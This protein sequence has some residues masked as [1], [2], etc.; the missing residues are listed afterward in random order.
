MN[1]HVWNQSS[2]AVK[3]SDMT[4]MMSMG[5]IVRVSIWDQSSKG[6]QDARNGSYDIYEDSRQDHHLGLVFE[7]FVKTPDMAVMTTL[8]RPVK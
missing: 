2:Q 5:T 7:R 3:T 6:R 4:V 1:A 8:M